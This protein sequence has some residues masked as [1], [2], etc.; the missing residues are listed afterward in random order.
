VALGAGGGGGGGAA[1]AEGLLKHNAGSFPEIILRPKG[2]KVGVVDSLEEL[3]S[4]GQV[5]GR[6]RAD[7]VDVPGAVVGPGHAGLEERLEAGNEFG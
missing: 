5:E 6:E 4:V 2:L 7:V 1:G 3:L